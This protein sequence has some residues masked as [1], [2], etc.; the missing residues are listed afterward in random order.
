M[1][2][3][4]TSN[5]STNVTL[6]VWLHPKRDAMIIIWKN[7]NPILANFLEVGFLCILLIIMKKSHK[8]WDQDAILLY[9]QCLSGLQGQ[10]WQLCKRKLVQMNQYDT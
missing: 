10:S 2:Y 9:M 4:P 1:K 8:P 7:A 3:E 6:V 5:D